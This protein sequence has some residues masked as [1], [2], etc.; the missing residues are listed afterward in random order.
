VV[1]GPAPV[2][3]PAPAPAPSPSP[4]GG[5]T[6]TTTTVGGTIAIN[7]PPIS[8]IDRGAATN[9]PP[10]QLVDGQYLLSDG[11]DNS[12]PTS[13]FGQPIRGLSGNDNLTGSSN[14]DTIFGDRGSDIINGGD[15]NDSLFGG[16][17][18]DQLSGGNGDDF[19]SGNNHNDTLTGGAGNDIMRG[20]KDNDVLLGGDGNDELWGDRGFDALTGGAGN[21]TFVLQFT[22]TSADQADVITDFN[23]TDDKIRL[24][25]F[26]FSQLSF[27]SV[28]VVLDG[29]TAVASTA[30]KS[31]NDYL[32]VVYNV[33]STA[34]SSSSFL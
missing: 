12:I 7:T 4:S 30:I 3:T 6:T 8:L 16:K 32:G 25:G 19:L 2:F 17:E 21:D 20:G 24:V 22:A 9:L 15:G 11:D 14:G 27:E 18:S 13:A 10:N 28:S 33:N 29:A 26:T 23:S 5:G 31:G 1:N 34:L